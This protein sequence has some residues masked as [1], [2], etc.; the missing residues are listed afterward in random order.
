MKVCA[1]SSR[2]HS[3]KSVDEKPN[4]ASVMSIVSSD[5]AAASRLYHLRSLAETGAELAR[6]KLIGFI[7]GDVC[8]W[9]VYLNREVSCMPVQRL[10]L[11][12][13]DCV[14]A[15]VYTMIA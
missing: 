10:A 15:C 5:M 8:E 14:C 6:P 3:G 12:C 9:V 7:N 1:N 2:L 11:L 13:D 4:I